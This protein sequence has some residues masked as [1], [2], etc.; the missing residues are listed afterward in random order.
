MSNVLFNSFLNVLLDNDPKYT[1][2][3][4]NTTAKYD[5]KKD[6]VYD[7]RK[8]DIW[9]CPKGCSFKNEMN[10]TLGDIF[11]SNITYLNNLGNITLE[12]VNSEDG[13]PSSGCY[14]MTEILNVPASAYI[15]SKN[16]YPQDCKVNMDYDYESMNYFV[17]DCCAK[18]NYVPHVPRLSPENSYDVNK[19][20]NELSTKDLEYFTD[21]SAHFVTEYGFS[22][23]YNS[24]EY[25]IYNIPKNLLI[26]DQV[27]LK[28]TDG[29]FDLPA[30][31]VNGGA[32]L[33]TW[34]DLG[35]QKVYSYHSELLTS[36][37]IYNRMKQA[38]SGLT[39]GEFENEI[40]YIPVAYENF[41]INSAACIPVSYTELP[42]NYN[43]KNTKLNIQWSEDGVF[44]L[45]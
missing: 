7:T 14:Q 36:G 32:L 16:N 45:K 25:S 26:E 18:N 6:Y 21:N 12:N 20:S 35:K 3:A 9:L 34:T 4:E 41:P 10:D 13:L 17:D 42:K 24:D 11:S 22:S 1:Q 2:L 28:T 15:F 19:V 23:G 31:N 33:I 29:N 44:S 27:N 43:L 38:N 40:R 37:S 5:T 39:V 8:F 30:I